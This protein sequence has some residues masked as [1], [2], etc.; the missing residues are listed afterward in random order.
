MT[1]EQWDD[2]ALKPLNPFFQFRTC[3]KNKNRFA[4]MQ[5]QECRIVELFAEE[6]NKM[7][8]EEQLPYEQMAAAARFEFKLLEQSV[9][10]VDDEDN[11]GVE[12]C[13]NS[14]AHMFYDINETLACTSEPLYAEFSPDPSFLGEFT[15]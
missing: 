4:G 8:P 2:I 10:I 3:A 1:K 9:I 7:S 6:W 15:V 13:R 11:D 12:P 14:E 5:R